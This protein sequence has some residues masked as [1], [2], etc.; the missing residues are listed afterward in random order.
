[1]SVYKLLAYD[2]FMSFNFRTKNIS[3]MAYHTE[4][5]FLHDTQN[6]KV[7]NIRRWNPKTDSVKQ[8]RT[9]GNPMKT[10]IRKANRVM[11]CLL[12]SV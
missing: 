11:P 1:M 7:C 3:I 6:T 8:R 9:E 12:C 4:G 10:W 2:L 5:L